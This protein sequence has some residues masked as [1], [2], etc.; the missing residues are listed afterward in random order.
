MLSVAASRSRLLIF[1]LLALAVSGCTEN[2]IELPLFAQTQS[3]PRPMAKPVQQKPSAAAHVA[4]PGSGV[5]PPVPAFIAPPLA[6]A[7]VGSYMDSLE[8]DLRRHVHGNGITIARMGDDISVILRSDRLFAKNGVLAA[9]DILEPLGALLGTVA[10]HLLGF[11]GVWGLCVVVGLA[12]FLAVAPKKRPPRPEGSRVRSA[13]LPASTVVPGIA[14]S[15]A[16]LGYAALAA[17]VALHMMARGVANGIAAFNAFG[18]TYVGVRLFIGNVPDRFGARQVAFWSALVETVGLLIVALAGNLPTVIVGG[19]VMGAGLSLL[20]PSLALVVINN[21]DT[22]QQGAALGA[23]TSFWDIGIAVGAPLAG[24]IASVASYPAIY[25]VMA[26]CAVGSALLSAPGAVRSRWAAPAS[27][28]T[29]R[30][31]VAR[32]PAR[33]LA[34]DGVRPPVDSANPAVGSG[35]GLGRDREAPP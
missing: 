27:A 5:V 14:L 16:A 19:L 9:D 2:Q 31:A 34:G 18:F 25:Y 4:A 17:F 12:G 24:L 22:S 35:P 29:G 8:S 11:G 7:R 15:L 10:M 26:C 13:I 33:D 3:A 20:F 30:R 21:S 28:M 1:P 32:R 23:F 6:V